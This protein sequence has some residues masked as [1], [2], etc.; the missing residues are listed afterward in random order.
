M[1]QVAAFAEPPRPRLQGP[2]RAVTRLRYQLAQGMRV[3]W[4]GAHYAAARAVSAPFDRPGEPRFRPSSPASVAAMRTAF[5][6]LFSQDL[7]N[8]Q[9]GLYPLP[10]DVR[11]SALPDAL[12]HIAQFWREVPRVDARRLARSG[13]EVRT[14][15]DA[16]RFPVYYRQNFHYQSDGW[17]SAESARV[18][19]TQVEVLFTGAAAAMRRAAL[20]EVA[21]ELKGRDPRTQRLLDVG[22]GTGRFLASLLELWPRLA[23]TGLDLSPQYAAYAR[24]VLAPF[25]H[26]EIVEGLAEAQPFADGQFDLITSVY[27]FHE[28]PPRVRGHVFAEIARVLKPGG[29][30]VFADA[31]QTGETPGLDGLLEY[32]PEGF[33]EP[34]FR[35]YLT[36]DFDALAREAGLEPEETVT[37]AFLT[38]VRRFRKPA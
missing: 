23:A 20:A 25:V 35:S 16:E 26:A 33:H 15:P 5:D 21:R 13:V 18:Y 6:A 7:A 31:L 10:R 32:F 1:S 30:F 29:V 37:R 38:R 34:Y 19:D 36:T 8:V 2:G 4:Y 28:L 12:A 3:V 22:C 27:L 11:P 24:Q 14:L 9:A 17:L